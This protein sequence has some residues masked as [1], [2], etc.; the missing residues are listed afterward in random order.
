MKAPR[1]THLLTSGE[2][3]LLLLRLHTGNIRKELRRRGTPTGHGA[4]TGVARL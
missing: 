1:T 4:G 2:D 3:A